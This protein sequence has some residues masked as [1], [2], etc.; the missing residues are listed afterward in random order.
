MHLLLG[1]HPLLESVSIVFDRHNCDSALALAAAD[2]TLSIVHNCLRGDACAD[3]CGDARLPHTAT[4]CLGAG[5][6]GHGGAGGQSDFL[7]KGR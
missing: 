2:K 4:H 1:G 7:G 5:V 3:H 6:A